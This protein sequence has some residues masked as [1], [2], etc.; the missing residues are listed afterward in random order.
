[1]QYFWHRLLPAG[2]ILLLTGCAGVGVVATSDPRVKLSDAEYLCFH[3]DRPVMADKLIFEAIQICKDKSDQACLAQG[4]RAYGFFFKSACVEHWEKIY[5]KYGFNDKS[6]SYD[7]RF[8]KS[9]EYFEKSRQI[10]VQLEDF[11]MVTNVDLNTGYAYM[12]MGKK[13]LACRAF[14]K[15]VVSSREAIRRHPDLPMNLPK[16]YSSYDEF[17]ASVKNREGCP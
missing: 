17:I 11:G 2:L 9:V 5:R 15:S 3:E 4:Y 10:F 14:D 8:S 13:N 7:D 1:M 12:L 16:G 6:A